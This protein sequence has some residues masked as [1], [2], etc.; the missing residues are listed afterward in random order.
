VLIENELEVPAPL[1]RTWAQ[2]SRGLLPD[3]SRRLTAQFAECP[4]TSMADREWDAPARTSV[5]NR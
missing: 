5:I 4:G 3:V 1:D 2:L